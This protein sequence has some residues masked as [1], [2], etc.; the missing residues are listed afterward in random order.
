MGGYQQISKKGYNLHSK[1]RDWIEEDK[2]LS[3][4]LSDALSTFHLYEAVML[5][6]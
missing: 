2:F 3:K 5:K 6:T 1:S 4:R